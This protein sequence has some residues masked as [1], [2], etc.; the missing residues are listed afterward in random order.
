M[1]NLDV[2]DDEIR[3]RRRQHR[4]N[5]LGDDLRHIRNGR[6]DVR[7]RAIFQII[8]FV[9]TRDINTLDLR[10]FSEKSQ[11]VEGRRSKVAVDFR[12]LTFEFLHRVDDIVNDF[13][14]LADHERVDEGMHRLGVHGGVSTGD[15][16]GMGLITVLRADRDA[17]QVEDVEGVGVES[18]VGQGK[19]DQVEAGQGLF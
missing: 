4:H 9:E 7:D 18:L 17:G 19:A 5:A 8:G 1:D 16:D 2:R 13:L 11:A 12:H 15:D 14:A 10:Q 6:L 3:R